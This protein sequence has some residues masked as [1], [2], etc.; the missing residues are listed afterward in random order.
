MT[1]LPFTG[2][3]VVPGRVEISLWH[4][5]IV[6]YLF[7]REFARDAVVLDVGCGSGYGAQCLAEAGARRVVG[8]D[9]ARD[10]IAYAALHYQSAN[11]HFAVMDAGALALGSSVFDLVT[12][13]EVIEHL[14]DQSKFLG[15]VARGLKPTGLLLLST[16]NRQVYRVGEEPNPFHTHEFEREE[17]RELLTRFFPQVAIL[18]QNYL[19]GICIGP[20]NGS[21]TNGESLPADGTLVQD[22]PIDVYFFAICSHQPF[23][24]PPS[25]GMF[26]PL[27][28]DRQRYLAQLQAELEDKTTWALRLRKELDEKSSEIET[29]RLE[30]ETVRLEKDAQITLLR[31]RLAAA[32]N[33]RSR[34]QQA[35]EER[36]PAEREAPSA[37]SAWGPLLA[38][39]IVIRTP[40]NLFRHF[41]HFRRPRPE[42]LR[43]AL[44]VASASIDKVA[45]ITEAVQ[46]KYP[47]ASVTVY[48]RQGD[49]SELRERLP[50]VDVRLVN[51]AEYRRRPLKLLR[52]LWHQKYDLAVIP[53]TAEKGFTRMKLLGFLSGASFVLLYNEN[54]DSF[55]W[56]LRHVRSI[57][58]HLAWRLRSQRLRPISWVLVLPLVPVGYTVVLARALPLLGRAVW[59]RWKGR[60]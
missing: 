27:S 41:F 45:R 30:V 38:A 58:G 17:L 4:E 35:E 19:A 23:V 5:H 7:A 10:A 18:S 13:F 54:V 33:A 1:D 36:A 56:M 51:T 8:V 48:S 6:R 24:E 29:M 32:E 2:E 31:Q 34:L 55:F 22:A 26:F 43:R 37:A 28:Y 50:A 11:L 21:I 15:E 39:F 42:R 3:R 25:A 47:F 57:A 60:V 20:G 52:E 14:S 16:P 12:C 44:V 46:E 59:N 53:A 40:Y 49:D 9:N